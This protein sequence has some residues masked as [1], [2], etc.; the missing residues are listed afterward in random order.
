[1]SNQS[2]MSDRP[3]AIGGYQNIFVA[4]AAGARC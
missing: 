4:D 3:G 1:M 2:A